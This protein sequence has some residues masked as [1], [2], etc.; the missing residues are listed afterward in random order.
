MSE[1]Q[2]EYE[3]ISTVEELIAYVKKYADSIY[4]RYHGESVAYNK[5]PLEIQQ[6]TLSR[7]I[8]FREIPFNSKLMD[9]LFDETIKSKPAL[10]VINMRRF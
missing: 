8:E 3:A 10:M 1:L 6:S 9:Y 7:W 5:L 2:V 4:T